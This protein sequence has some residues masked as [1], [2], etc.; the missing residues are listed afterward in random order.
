MLDRDRCGGVF[1]LAYG[2][3][4][5]KDGVIIFSGIQHR[6]RALNP[7]DTM[8][9]LRRRYRCLSGRF[10]FTKYMVVLV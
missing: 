4:V 10:L 1:N 8:T 9:T 6:H 2:L 3:A 7:H 5:D